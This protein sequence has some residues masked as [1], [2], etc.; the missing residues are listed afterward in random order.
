MSMLEQLSIR[1]Q[2]LIVEETPFESWSGSHVKDW[3]IKMQ[4][5]TIGDLADFPL[6]VAQ[7]VPYASLLTVWAYSAL[8]DLT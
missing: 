5:L 3:K 1:T 7:A 2:G 8:L 4:M 6:I